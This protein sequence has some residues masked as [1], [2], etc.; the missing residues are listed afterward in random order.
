MTATE[1]PTMHLAMSPPDESGGGSSDDPSSRGAAPRPRVVL[2]ADAL[3]A[4]LDETN[5][6][7]SDLERVQRE[8][9]GTVGLIGRE[10]AEASEWRAR[11]AAVMEPLAA[12]ERARIAAEAKADADRQGRDAAAASQRAAA[13]SRIVDLLTTIVSRENRNTVLIILFALLALFRPDLA[14]MYARVF[15]APVDVVTPTV[16][17]PPPM[18]AP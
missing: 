15:G 7:L 9:S 12:R 5:R 8:I 18:G 16:S 11:M 13:W 17:N 14:A 2:S 1:P 3:T 10:T 4:R 6:R